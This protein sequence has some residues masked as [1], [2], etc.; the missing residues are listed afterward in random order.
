MLKGCITSNTCLV[1][2]KKPVLLSV[3]HKGELCKSPDRM[4]Q[5]YGMF[6]F[7]Y[8]VDFVLSYSDYLFIITD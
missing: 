3:N 7:E 5:K 2:R 4:E 6:L 1:P 8:F